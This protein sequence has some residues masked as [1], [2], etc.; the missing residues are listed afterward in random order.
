MM[1]RGWRRDT[2][3]YCKV[4]PEKYTNVVEVI[5]QTDPEETG[6]DE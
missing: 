5:Q 3:L 2:G 6:W 1:K 4:S